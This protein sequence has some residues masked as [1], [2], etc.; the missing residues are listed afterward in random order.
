MKKIAERGKAAAEQLKRKKE[1][2]GVLKAQLRVKGRDLKEALKE[3]E[4]Q[5]ENVKK[6]RRALK[7]ANAEAQHAT[8]QLMMLEEERKEE[9]KE[10]EDRKRELAHRNEMEIEQEVEAPF[11]LCINNNTPV[12]ADRS[13]E[14][15]ETR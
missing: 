4:Q 2:V 7:R 13:N 3:I 14:R 9:D 15:A 10:E 8:F 1:D 6:L 11:A 12:V 5:K